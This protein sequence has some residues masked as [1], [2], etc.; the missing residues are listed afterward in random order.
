MH[1]CQS[2]H[3]KWNNRRTRKR[4]RR[5]ILERLKLKK[6][7]RFSEC[8]SMGEIIDNVLLFSRPKL[9]FGIGGCQMEKSK[10][11]RIFSLPEGSSMDEYRQDFR[12]AKELTNA[13]SAAITEFVNKRRYGGQPLTEK[14]A[15][16]YAIF[17]E[18]YED[19]E[20]KIKAQSL[21]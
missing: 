10:I 1:Y 17:L 12:F 5:Q 7:F 15:K 3:K 21:I 13:G 18:M 20:L 19:L 16:I 8:H 4:N 11:I 14:E 6:D 2:G 9:F